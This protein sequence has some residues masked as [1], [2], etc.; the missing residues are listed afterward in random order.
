VD[1][2]QAQQLTL[3]RSRPLPGSAYIGARAR[4]PP[5][6]PASLARR[7]NAFDVEAFGHVPRG[8]SGPHTTAS[9]SSVKDSARSLAAV[10]A[11]AG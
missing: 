8:G 4:S 6:Y 5:C 3:T 9:P 1:R 11:I 10:A 2:V 7:L